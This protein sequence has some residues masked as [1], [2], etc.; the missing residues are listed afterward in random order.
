[1]K[2]DIERLRELLDLSGDTLRALDTL[3][4][5]QSVVSYIIDKYFTCGEN[6]ECEGLVKLV[7]R[8]REWL[9]IYEC[10]EKYDVSQVMDLCLDDKAGVNFNSLEIDKICI[11]LFE[12]VYFDNLKLPLSEDGKKLILDKIKSKLSSLVDNIDISYSKTLIMIVELLR[13]IEHD[14]TKLREDYKKLYKKLKGIHV[15]I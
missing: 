15:E 13:D 11:D 14:L 5:I 7:K 6:R 9:R 2:R 10:V 3:S 1:M 12:C 8:I 4:R